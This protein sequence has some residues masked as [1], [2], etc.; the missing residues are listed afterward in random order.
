MR[1]S[2]VQRKIAVLLLVEP[3]TIEEI[4]KQLDLGF[5]A[6]TNEIN[7]MLK[8]GLVKKTNEYP[9]RYVLDDYIIAELKKRKEIAEKDSYRIKIQMILDV[10]GVVKEIVDKHLDNLKGF[11][12]KEKDI[13]IYDVKKS[14]LLEQDNSYFGYIDV[15]C[16]VK[17]FASLIRLIMFYAP[18][19]IE[20]LSP[21]KY[22]ISMYELQDGIIELSQ[23]TQI[24]I[25]EL[26]KRLTQEEAQLALKKFYRV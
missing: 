6:I 18:S 2:E 7:T 13:T 15:T 1:I 8:I 4:N 23:R 25:K 21:T 5:E 9:T 24:Y 22:D 26:Q 17:D 12:D 20:I 19:S 16:T 14:E 3:K 11:L 10:E